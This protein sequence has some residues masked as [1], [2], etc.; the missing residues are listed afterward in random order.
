MTHLSFQD[1]FRLFVLSPISLTIL[2][3]A[4][5]LCHPNFT[6]FQ[7]LV[8]ARIIF[9]VSAFDV[10]VSCLTEAAGAM[11]GSVRIVLTGRCWLTTRLT[12]PPGWLGHD[13]S[14]SLQ[15]ERKFCE[16]GSIICIHSAYQACW[17]PRYLGNLSFIYLFKMFDR[18]NESNISEDDMKNVLI[19]SLFVGTTCISYILRKEKFIM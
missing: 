18:K 11:L 13:S 2:W 15:S 14:H 12:R 1:T 8:R 3:E 10:S 19:K 16:L 5:G 9:I 17:E 6:W 7:F 4:Q